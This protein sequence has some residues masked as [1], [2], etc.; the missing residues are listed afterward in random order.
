MYMI[1]AHMLHDMFIA[2]PRWTTSGP[3]EEAEDRHVNAREIMAA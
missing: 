1:Q 3:S 2:N